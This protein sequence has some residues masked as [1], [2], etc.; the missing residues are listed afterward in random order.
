MPS[1]LDGATRALETRLAAAFPTTPIAWPNV[2][3]A[4]P[5]GLLWLRPWVLWAAG[6]LHTMYPE[7]LNVVPGLYQV[8]I[9]SP[10]S[11]GAGVA[12]TLADQVRTLFRRA[13]FGGVRC[14]VPSGPV[15]LP[16]EPPWYGVSVSIPFH[17]VE[18]T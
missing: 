7:R 8:S 18:E 5:V 11:L 12:L 9:Y 17:V 1:A 4:A 15:V 16:E 6:A 3:F 10:Q 14:D 13:V 2:E